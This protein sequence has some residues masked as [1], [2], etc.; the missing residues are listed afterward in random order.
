M[1]G[2]LVRPQSTTDREEKRQRST[3]LEGPKR[4]SIRPPTPKISRK[5][6]SNA[7]R[8]R[9]AEPDGPLSLD[10]GCSNDRSKID[11]FQ[12]HRGR[13]TLIDRR[14]PSVIHVVEGI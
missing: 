12:F 11:V 7:R 9:R 6:I 5:I 8:H 10:F 1:Y 4:L 2:I 3:I 13:V 14:V